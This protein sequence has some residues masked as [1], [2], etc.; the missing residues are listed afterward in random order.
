MQVRVGQGFDVHPFIDDAER[1]LILGGVTFPSERALR[2]H[3]D[4]DGHAAA[5]LRRSDRQRQL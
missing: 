2:G 5:E 3:S 1:P 4:A